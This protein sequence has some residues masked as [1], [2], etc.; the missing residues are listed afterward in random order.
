MTS[1]VYEDI[2][3]QGGYPGEHKMCAR[4]DSLWGLS[5]TY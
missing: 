1:V 2:S 4:S 3:E 5:R